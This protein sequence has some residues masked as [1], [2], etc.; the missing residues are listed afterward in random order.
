MP[1]P[2]AQRTWRQNR[3]FYR[4]IPIGIRGETP[5]PEATVRLISGC[6][7]N[8]LSLD[9]TFNRLFT[10]TLLATWANANFEGNYRD[11]HKA[12][13][14]QMPP[15]QSPNHFITGPANPAFD[16]EKPFAV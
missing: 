3:D 5:D 13:L 6:Q 16:D 9:G 7:D 11:F 2:V 15:T 10:G 12:I 14:K 4:D 8:Q 1:R